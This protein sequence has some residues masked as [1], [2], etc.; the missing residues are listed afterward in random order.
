MPVSVKFPTVS[1]FM[2][3]FP[4]SDGFAVDVAGDVLTDS[5]AIDSVL[6]FPDGEPDGERN[7]GRRLKWCIEA[8]T[9]SR[10]KVVAD[11]SPA[12]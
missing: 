1:A 9:A 3:L 7:G 5:G 11:I 4:V 10:R 2:A 8:R 12:R 6:H